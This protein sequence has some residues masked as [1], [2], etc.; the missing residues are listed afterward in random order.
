MIP[1]EDR[2][3]GGDRVFFAENCVG[4][5]EGRL[6]DGQACVHVA[7]IDDAHDLSGPRRNRPDK[8]VVIVAIAIDDAAP[9]AVEAGNSLLLEQIQ[10]M[11]SKSAPLGV[12][13]RGKHLEGPKR[14]AEIPLQNA[15]CR[16]VRKI[17][18]GRVHLGKEAAET[19]QEF[20]RMGLH[21]GQCGTRQEREQPDDAA[22]AIGG[23]HVREQL[24][25]GVGNHPG[26]SKMRRA[27]SQM[28]ECPALHV[29]E[30]ILARGVHDFQNEGASIRSGQMEVIVVFAGQRSHIRVE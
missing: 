25:A 15:V 12:N 5:G 11:L 26:K 19:L 7:K 23:L 30:R 20:G 3:C 18:E 8:S 17:Q 29:N 14:P 27:V 28:G 10:E 22:G 2:P 16:R 6:R 21:F 1:G 13:D 4:R 9:E 24:A